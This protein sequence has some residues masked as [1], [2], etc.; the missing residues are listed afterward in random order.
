M[1]ASSKRKFQI[2][3]K[4]QGQVKKHPLGLERTIMAG[5]VTEP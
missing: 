5:F 2:E 4:W 3:E 1:E